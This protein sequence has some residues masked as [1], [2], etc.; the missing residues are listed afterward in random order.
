MP[1]FAVARLF[2]CARRT[3]AAV[4]LGALALALAV[5]APTALATGGGHKDSGAAAYPGA[6]KT[7]A[8][9]KTPKA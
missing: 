5:L 3:R 1:D 7:S 8:K 2:A 4:L 6:G 9:A